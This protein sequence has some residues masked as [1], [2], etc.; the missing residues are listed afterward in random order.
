MSDDTSGRGLL[1]V[2]ARPP[3]ETGR[4]IAI[5]GARSF[6][7]KNLLALLEDDP[8]VDRLLALDDEAHEPAPLTTS[9]KVRVVHTDLTA[10]GTDARL[11]EHLEAEDIDTIV[12]VAFLD[13]PSH[14]PAFAHELES[15]GSMRLLR[16]ARRAKTRK[17]VMWSHT[18]LYGANPENPNFLREEAKLRAP[19]REPWFSDKVEAEQEVAR[20]REQNPDVTVTV[21]RTAPILGPTVDNVVTRYLSRRL[22]PTLMGFDPLVQLLH[23]VDAIGALKWAIFRNVPGI[24]NIAADGV[25][26]LSTVIKLAGRTPAPLPGFMARQGAAALWMAQ[27]AEAPPAFL[28][29]LRYLC[30]ADGGKARRAGHEPTF[31]SREAVLDFVSAQRLRDAKLLRVDR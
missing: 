7:G 29:H 22:V 28:R 18:W 10:P 14:A 19:S 27:L 25:L 21:L 2:S 16:A 1:D 8:K 30:V 13:L 23:E 9:S 3:R 24:Y 11:A 6:L 17:L 31:T 26:P 20:F 4:R 5:A 15:V 12:H